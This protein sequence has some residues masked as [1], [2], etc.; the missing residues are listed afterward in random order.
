MVKELK[1]QIEDACRYLFDESIEVELTRPEESFGDFSTNVALK[2][3]GKLQKSP[4]DIA[5]EIVIRLQDNDKLQE[6]NVAGPGFI[7]IRLKDRA[8]FES[9]ISIENLSKSLAGKTIV[10]EY[11]DPNPFKI[12]HAGHL[13]TSIVGDTISNILET[14]GAKVHRVNYGGD[15]GLHVAKTMW[16]M[17]DDL[18]GEHAGKLEY[19]DE[20]KRSDW[21]AGCYVKG[22]KAYEEDT[23]TK[24]EINELNKRI[25]KISLEQDKESEL[26]KIY[27]QTRKWSYDYFDDF[28]AR[29]GI[30]F[31]K[32]YPESTVVNQ[33]LETVKA[34]TPEIY[35]QSEGAIIYRGEEDGLHTRVFITKE[36][37]PTYEAK[38][39][40]LIFQKKQDYDFDKS[41]IITANE[42]TQ[43]MRVVLAS[44]AKFAPDLVARTT[45]LT[46]GMVKLPGAEKMSSR[47]GNFLRAVDIIDNAEQTSKAL[48]PKT[49]P[50][51]VLGAV[52]YSFLKSSLGGDIIFDA[53]ESVSL[54]GNS[55]PYLQYALVRAN[56]ILA[57]TDADEASLSEINQLNP[58]ERSLLRKLTAYPEVIDTALYE[59]APH[60]ICGYLYE[61]AQTFNRFY[62]NN[63]VIGDKRSALRLKL[64]RSYAQVL[65]NGLGILGIETPAS[66]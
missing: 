38:E 5:Q 39:I 2:L 58:T 49:T 37:L 11:S 48:N 35:S 23:Q 32:Y 10:T 40:G 16:A 30:S 12:L 28:Y 53:E 42:Q 18:K 29:L 56:S 33:G 13:Y 65:D 41:I 21:L 54:E 44:L 47:K 45:H 43:Y 34:N 25:Y 14:A 60:H 4:R 17:I 63:K 15:V 19:I 8:L 1:V 9:L 52:K 51:I 20:N 3:A 64:V 22:T 24:Q 31:E 62:E 57:K 55:G 46:H 26:G 50:A 61:L 6:V 36:G 66:M 27:W 7:N 59:L